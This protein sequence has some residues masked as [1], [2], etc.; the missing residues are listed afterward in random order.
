MLGASH[1]FNWRLYGDRILEFRFDPIVLPD[2]I[3]DEPGSH[4]FVLFQ[5]KPRAGLHAGDSISNRAGIYFDYNEPVITP[6]AVFRVIDI[7]S[8]TAHPGASALEFGL[9]PNPASQNTSVRL[10]LPESASSADAFIAIYDQQGRLLRQMRSPA[11]QRRVY[12]SD[13]PVG[14][15]VVQVGVNGLWGS[16]VLVVK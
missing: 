11:G 14:V 6:A 3:S 16:K 4:G 1:P 5:V 15:C 2:S 13:L 10:E 9:S 7:S 8:G 12:L